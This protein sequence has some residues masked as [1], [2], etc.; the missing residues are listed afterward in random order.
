MSSPA[1]TEDSLCDTVGV[2]WTRHRGDAAGD[3]NPSVGFASSIWRSLVAVAPET[4]AFIPGCKTH[5]LRAAA[6]LSE[7]W[8]HHTK[9]K[10]HCESVTNGPIHHHWLASTQ[11]II[12]TENKTCMTCFIMQTCYSLETF[13]CVTAIV[14]NISSLLLLLWHWENQDLITTSHKNL[15]HSV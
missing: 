9:K 8:D 13:V 7:A 15:M 11:R 5:F 14:L 4:S 10:N 3:P 1:E 2:Q 6:R 12:N